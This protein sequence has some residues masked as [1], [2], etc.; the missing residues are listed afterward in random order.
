MRTI[1]FI[2]AFAIAAAS[3]GAVISTPTYSG[4][5]DSNMAVANGISTVI[6]GDSGISNVSLWQIGTN[7]SLA[8]SSGFSWSG[9][10]SPS[11]ARFDV[12]S[13]AT[14]F[15]GTPDSGNTLAGAISGDGSFVV[16]SGF[17]TLT[18]IN[19]YTGGTTVNSGQLTG[20]SLSIQGDIA[21]AL[22]S[23]SFTQDFDGEYSGI[24][25][26]TPDGT[27][28]FLT[29][30]GAGMLRLTAD[31]AVQ[32]APLRS[33]YV[34]INGGTLWLG[35]GGTSG[36]IDGV[37]N[38]D[39]YTGGNSTLVVDLAKDVF[40]GGAIVSKNGL[41]T[42]MRKLGSG[43]LSLVSAPGSGQTWVEAGRM[44]VD[45]SSLPGTSGTGANNVRI[46][47]GA[48]FVWKNSAA[49]DDDSVSNLSGSGRAIKRGDGT[50]GILNPG[51]FSG[52][53]RVEGGSVDF[54]S[55]SGSTAW[56]MSLDLWSGT[57]ALWR[58][59]ENINFAGIISGP[60]LFTKSGPNTLTLTGTNTATGLVT[61]TAGAIEVGDG[62]STG[63][64]VSDIALAGGQ[65]RW[66]KS[67]DDI[68]SNVI[69]G[70]GP[71]AKAGNG[72]LTLTG[73]NTFT[74]GTTIAGGSLFIGGDSGSVAGNI[75]VGSGS[76]FGVNKENDVSLS[77]FINGF[78]GLAK[79]GNGTLTL[80][81]TNSYSG[82]TTI[83]GGVLQVGDG[84][85]T[86]SLVS[87]VNIGSGSRF[88]WNKSTVVDT[89]GGV[90]S[91]NGFFTKS[92]VGTLAL[93]GTNTATGL[94]TVSGGILQIGN[95]GATG[96]IGSSIALVGGHLRWNKST[97]DVFSGTISGSG[98]FSKTGTGTLTLTGNNTYTGA[99]SLTGGN[100]QIGN[101]GSDGSIV[102][103][104]DMLPGRRLTW[105][106]ST[107]DTYGGV[108]SGNGAFF[109]KT[110]TG[111]LT[112]TGSNTATGLTTVSG[113]T[114]EIGNGGSSGWIG[115]NIA[116]L[117]GRLRFNKS[118]DDLFA[119]AITGTGS[120]TKAG[121][122]V[123]TLTGNNT[124]TG[125]TTIAGG[126]LRYL[127]VAVPTAISG[128]GSS[129]RL[130]IDN[131]AAGTLTSALT[132]GMVLGKG[133]A[134]TLTIATTL[135]NTSG[136]FVSGGMVR[137]TDA[138]P[139]FDL[140]ASPYSITIS[141]T[142]Y[143]YVERTGN[144]R[145]DISQ[146]TG[147]SGTF[148]KTGAGTLTL[149]GNSPANGFLGATVVSQGILR[150]EGNY[151]SPIT[152][153]G[154]AKLVVNALIDGSQEPGG[155]IADSFARVS[156]SGTIERTL[157]INNDAVLA[158]GNSPG[159]LTMDSLILSSSSRMEYEL[160]TPGIVGSNVND[161]SIVTGDVTLD[162]FLDVVRYP[163]FGLGTYRL[164]D[165]GGILTN[166]GLAVGTMPFGYTAANF[167]V[168]T[169]PGQVNL[170]VVSTG[171]PDPIS[172]EFWFNGTT[173]APVGHIVG[174][175]GM[176]DN[177]SARTNWS[178]AGGT[179]S[180]AWA[181]PAVAMFAGAAGNVDVAEDVLISGAKFFS[182]GYSLAGVGRIGF[183]NAATEFNTASG[184]TATIA[185]ELAGVGGVRKT[186]A[187]SLVLTGAN[188]F[189]G[190][191]SI[192]SGT[193]QI[194]NGGPTGSIQ[195]NVANSADFKWNKSSD[196]TFS[197]NISG[198]GRFT[199]MGSGKLIATG[200]ISNS[201]GITISGGT[202]QVGDGGTTGSIT[203]R[204]DNAGSLV[205][206][207][208]AD[209]SFNTFIS[210]NGT[211]TKR[212][213]GTL[214]LLTYR[215]DFTGL[216]TIEEGRLLVRLSARVLGN[217]DTF[218]GTQFEWDIAGAGTE[219]LAGNISGAG[220]LVKSG[221]GTLT[222]T[223]NM[224]AAAGSTISSGVLRVGNGG[225]TGSLAGDV[226]TSSA[227]AWLAWRKSSADTF[228]GNLSGTGN[229]WVQGTGSLTLTGNATHTGQ[230][231]VASGSTLQIGNGSATGRISASNIDNS[232]VL[233]WNRTAADVYAGIISGSGAFTKRGSG[234][235]TLSGNS[236]GSGATRVEAGSLIVNGSTRSATTVES[237]AT[238]G[239]S[240][241][242]DNLVTIRDGGALAPGTS[243]GTISVA[244]LTLDP[245]SILNFEL[246][247]PGV[248]GSG[249]NDLIDVSGNL[250]LDGLLNVADAGGFTFGTYRLINYGGS[251]SDQGLTIN[252]VPLG[253]GAFV[254]QTSIAGQVN[255]I[256][257]SAG[258]YAF[259]NGTNLLPSGTVNG[260]NGVW[261][262]AAANT[263]W[264][265]APGTGTGP[266]AVGDAIFT[267]TPG[268]VDLGDNVAFNNMQFAVGG[269]SINGNGN[270][271]TASLPSSEIRT[272][273]GTTTISAAISGST[274][275]KTGAGTLALTGAN[276]YGDTLVSAGL[277]K[278]GTGG[279]S[280]TLGTG[281]VALAGG[282]LEFD[283]S[284]DIAV[285]NAIT[286][287]GGHVIKSGSNTLTY[288]G[289]GSAAATVNAG[290]LIVTGTLGDIDAAA[291]LGGTGTVGNVNASGT[292]APGLP[293]LAGT[294]NTLSLTLSPT[295][296]LAFDFGAPNIVGSGVNDLLN[297]VGNLVL[298][299]TLNVNNLG[300]FAHG[301]YRIAGY[302]GSLTN[303]GLALG[304]T[305]VGFD[306]AEMTIQTSIGGQINLVFAPAATG[307]F[308]NG[309][310]TSP[311]GVVEGG[312]GIWNNLAGNTN[313]SVASGDATGAWTPQF[314]IF[315]GTAGTSTLGDNVAATGIQFAADGYKVE[316]PLG[317]TL[318]LL[319]P[320]SAVR[321]DTGTATINAEIAGSVQLDKQGAGTLVLGGE[322]TYSG[323]TVVNRGVLQIGNGVSGSVA[324]N[325]D[326]A[327][328]NLVFNRDND[329]T[330]AN[331][332]TGPGS[333][334]KTG[335]GTLSIAGSVSNTGGVAINAGR[336][337]LVD[338]GSIS[339]NIVVAGGAV[340]SVNQSGDITLP[341]AISGAG[342]LVKDGTGI[343]TL[344]G[345][346]TYSGGT[347]VN[348]GR[349]IGDSN[350]LQGAIL[351]N[352]V[353][354]FNQAAAGTYGGALTGTG[355]LTKSGSGTLSITGSLA[356]T[357][358][359][360]IN[361]GRMDLL[362]VSSLAGNV[363]IA[364][365]AIL[366]VNRS[367]DMSLPG[368]I[369]GAGSLVKDGAGILD[370]TGTN[371]YSGGTTVNGGTLRGNSL[372]IQGDIANNAVVEFSQAAAGTYS[373]DMIGT[374]SL[375]KSGAG[376]LG[377]T[378]S[379][380]HTGG[381]AI[382]AGRLN[383]L[384]GGSIAGNV[385]VA[386]GAVFGVDQTLGTLTVP[387]AISGA[388]S[389]V[390]DGA[391]T[392]ILTGA[393]SYTGGTT[394]NAGVLQGDTASLQGAINNFAVVRFGQETDGNFAGVISG[395]GSVQKTGAGTLGL[396]GLHPYTGTTDL[397][398]GAIRMDN[399][400]LATSQFN[401]GPGTVLSGSGSIAGNLVNSGTV[402]PARIGLS[403][404]GDFTQ[405]PT[406][407]LVI[408]VASASDFSHLD[409]TG[410]ATLAG[411]LRVVRLDSYTPKV[412][413][414]LRIIDAAG[415]DGKFSV[416]EQS[417][418]VFTVD[419]G[420][421][422]V[423]L[424]VGGG[425]GPDPTP[426]P[427]PIQTMPEANAILAKKAV[428]ASIAWTASGL[429]EIA[430]SDTQNLASAL[431]TR[432]GA[433]R[434]GRASGFQ[435]YGLANA[436]IQP[437]NMG[438]PAGWSAWSSGSGTFSSV[439]QIKDVPKFN[440]VTGSVVVGADRKF[441]N[442][443]SAGVYGGYSGTISKQQNAGQVEVNTARAGIYGTYSKGAVWAAGSIGGTGSS[444]TLRRKD[445]L[446]SLTATGNPN[447]WGIE[448]SISGGYDFRRG[449][450]TVTP[451]ASAQLS[452]LAVDAYT[453]TGAG[454]MN[455]R[456]GS[457]TA[458]SLRGTLG[459]AASYDI[460]LSRDITLTP[461]ASVYYQREFL[462]NG[463]SLPV[464]L[465][466]GTG[467]RLDAEI[468]AGGRNI[469][470]GS[471]GATLRYK[472]NLSAFV[473]AGAQVSGTQ[474][475]ASVSAGLGISF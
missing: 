173:L 104:V 319:D 189:A 334:T 344:A 23:V 378:G 338:G 413:D 292:L 136:L 148:E 13:G 54:L 121:S 43:T 111:T 221:L 353:V 454:S 223:G 423:T 318:T 439:I 327:G 213:S 212:G 297:I 291:T 460:A 209:G 386:G 247:T 474:T 73:T 81:G 384:D 464:Q 339:N 324:G 430:F 231:V 45:T 86:G 109:T 356:H 281:S 204:I 37:T 172:T 345:T 392:L 410:S 461:N 110:G 310:T 58:V 126:T 298:D 156:G 96:S 29:K 171:N 36:W 107:A 117:G 224:T 120:L 433:I 266:W 134:G 300:G 42:F 65:L 403:I 112:L 6:D 362:D 425:P 467:T 255:L 348:A 450:L 166:S 26:G 105:N 294:L 138:T 443:F 90:L 243:P 27:S 399:A 457:Q 355:S 431:G 114:L 233:V 367:S 95:A 199:K 102:S 131:A 383:I 295:S 4:P 3:N 143:L 337:N 427:D 388:G 177:S 365:A 168:W 128:T 370:L 369:S 323:H 139:G 438:L 358:G 18:G 375:V 41:D 79:M 133:G 78:G 420:T 377:I 1:V 441:E 463:Y 130:Q 141:D 407:I 80:L 394:V 236:T 347:T 380:G 190:G 181:G 346:N 140:F 66:N 471:I 14:L 429:K 32:V 419:Y 333:L 293:G 299:G 82:G 8:M 289:A 59:G 411:T 63:F 99:T 226:R 302:S 84:G 432:G 188:T 277:L 175:S 215:N 315:T 385:A 237:G 146:F 100:L 301:S 170:D 343:M 452:V 279:T 227:D 228:A 185:N 267:A 342:S 49:R 465:S 62:G 106:K 144:E 97:S 242:I 69:S 33:A 254:V 21:M 390:K 72:T 336:L 207:R 435:S 87:G 261:N 371:T 290:S 284:D 328:G 446:N 249:V 246:S 163:G 47:A 151:L 135:A 17:L 252:S 10:A 250:V 122:G 366:G 25:R 449:A 317:Y 88:I 113:G 265:N 89:Y 381:T 422:N 180:N 376:V 309:S 216:T 368:A 9:S 307:P 251:I 447:S 306:P 325:I 60:G 269:Y 248:V 393:N 364:T 304:V 436:P 160:G 214:S 16:N 238:L 71:L 230:T 285:S 44:A 57:S 178:N 313:W 398:G 253:Y 232:G 272:D 46:D 308:W 55:N 12:A 132:G 76:I 218:A 240:G 183:R 303:L 11:L 7:A 451:F 162:G 282:N 206:N 196:S 149:G 275:N 270:T 332:I 462:D 402:F 262:N 405:M 280:G 442:G 64:I 198:S 92:G 469:V 276:M 373:G 351:D 123:L 458:A 187:G 456:V 200:D 94:T 305:P 195:G 83:S 359:T 142:G 220:E 379:L 326:L 468:G 424:R 70:T 176:W 234:A 329:S 219:T 349:L 108:I 445:P 179:A 434:S 125:S 372:A 165:F 28:R 127:T 264:T 192:E 412:G 311:S 273:A 396:T 118:S 137:L 404:G 320:V 124:Y 382:N 416:F 98:T 174:G 466:S 453:E 154:G 258:P 244:A 470:G 314:A 352:A 335:I 152:V 374:G 426:Q 260:G 421:D 30:S 208:S 20:T 357:G 475:T 191:L 217:V 472:E 312:T 31:S 331:I 74:G 268:T 159:T 38:F 15:G 35:N 210:G 440:Y 400:T 153:R 330:S 391:S 389:V 75:S 406:G 182:N 245:L 158:P 321:V 340:F 259:W 61:V 169:A 417:G 395:T 161:L 288:T 459:V 296:I 409:I 387:G 363:S 129:T 414:A 68:Y 194:G 437:E 202:L 473:S 203:A 155:V 164:I 256:V 186:G 39:L 283:R 77:G 93:T 360:A 408:E 34:D 150:V 2:A 201:T 193:V 241:R 229:L 50:L 147:T 448:S 428:G 56:S 286:G 167:V 51:R 271:M 53:F 322:N 444:Y 401:V 119:N 263:N 85:S 222:L 205:W 341:G 103:S 418:N 145:F 40:F 455:A 67:R 361:A 350:S 19:A 197:G 184:V 415:V 5:Y 115:S 101:G 157:T 239:G 52:L 235:L 91:G 22:G 225:T 287:I 211:L 316:S 354:E 257:N 24:I 278:I 397:I 48:E 116:L 274:I